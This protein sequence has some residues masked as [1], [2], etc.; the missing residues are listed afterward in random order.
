MIRHQVK[1]YILLIPLELK[2]SVLLLECLPPS[3]N[4]YKMQILTPENLTVGTERHK[5][6]E[7]PW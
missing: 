4:T 3:N 7:A 6:A 5:Q 1:K 2:N